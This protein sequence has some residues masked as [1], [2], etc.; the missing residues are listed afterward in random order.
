M[1]VPVSIDETGVTPR[2]RGVRT[3]LRFELLLGFDLSLA[4]VVPSAEE[5]E[6]GD[7]VIVAMLL[8]INVCSNCCALSSIVQCRFTA[9]A[10]S[11]NDESAS[12]FPVRRQPVMSV[13]RAPA[14]GTCGCHAAPPAWC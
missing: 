13:A 5:L 12:L 11:C 3:P 10:C 1:G 8:V 14:A 7:V 6:V 2:S 9:T 4:L